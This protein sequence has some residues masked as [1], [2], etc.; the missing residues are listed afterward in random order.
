MLARQLALPL[1]AL[2][3]HQWLSPGERLAPRAVR[4]ALQMC[5]KVQL[6]RAAKASTAQLA[7]PPL[8]LAELQAQ[9]DPVVT[10]VDLASAP[11]VLPK[12]LALLPLVLLAHQLEGQAPQAGP[13][14]LQI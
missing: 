8:V 12:L 7:S 6:E 9:R 5:R 10:L 3:A 13:A 1:L 14:M 2:L 4:A 11:G